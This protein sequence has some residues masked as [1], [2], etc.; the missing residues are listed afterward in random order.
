MSE[1]QN[2]LKAAWQDFS[3]KKQN[4]IRPQIESD[5]GI[6][7]STFYAWLS[8]GDKMPKLALPVFQKY[9]MPETQ[10]GKNVT[11]Q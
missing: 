8:K 2:E 5:C 3:A 11:K 1:T 7:T 4:L 9:I 6:S 10:Q